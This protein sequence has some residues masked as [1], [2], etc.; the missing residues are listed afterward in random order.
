MLHWVR[1]PGGYVVH[2][3]LVRRTADQLKRRR[4]LFFQ[5]CLHLAEVI[6]QVL[7]K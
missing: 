7:Q 4:Y 1:P 3:T 5:D 2:G 6:Y